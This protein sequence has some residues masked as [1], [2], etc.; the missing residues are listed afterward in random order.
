VLSFLKEHD[1]VANEEKNAVKYDITKCVDC[2]HCISI[3]P[4]KA[5]SFD[6]DNELVYDEDK[7]VLCGLCIDACP[8]RALS[9]PRF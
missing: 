8:R 3:C 2:G 7:C 6:K 5:F 9:K 4:T 1:V